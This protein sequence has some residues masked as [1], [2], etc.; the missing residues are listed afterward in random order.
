MQP[1]TLNSMKHVERQ[2]QMTNMAHTQHQ[3]QGRTAMSAAARPKK[4]CWPVAYTSAC[5][6]PC[7]MVEPEKQT[8]PANFLAGSDSPV[9][10]AW[11][12]CVGHTAGAAY[13]LACRQ[14]AGRKLEPVIQCKHAARGETPLPDARYTDK[15]A[16]AFSGSLPMPTNMSCASGFN[17]VRAGDRPETNFGV[18]ERFVC[19]NGR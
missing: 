6:S 4:V 8:S 17:L 14:E 2:Q 15:H 9:S 19:H 3:A 18:C 12:T 16:G 11:S 10:A 5:F 13:Q 7:L 1:G